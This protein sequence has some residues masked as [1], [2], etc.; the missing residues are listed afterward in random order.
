MASYDC[1]K[2]LPV[3][4]TDPMPVTATLFIPVMIP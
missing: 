4:L 1:L 2:E 3:G